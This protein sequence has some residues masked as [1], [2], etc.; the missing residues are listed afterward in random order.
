MSARF[1]HTQHLLPNPHPLPS[2]HTLSTHF[3][4]CTLST[5][6]PHTLHTLF[7]YS[8]HT[9]NNTLSRTH[10]PHT[11]HTL[12]THFPH[13]LHLSLQI[14][15]ALY[16]FFNQYLNNCCASTVHKYI[17]IYECQ[18]IFL[19]FFVGPPIFTFIFFSLRSE[20]NKEISRFLSLCFVSIVSPQNVF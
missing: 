14:C 3:Y 2:P 4:T 1:S 12:S 16:F 18:T 6:S 8:P 11:L 17:Y 9:L 19:F 15:L 10:S 7:K 13:T 5:H 20:T